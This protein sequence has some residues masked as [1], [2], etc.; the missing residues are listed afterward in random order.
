MNRYRTKIGKQRNRFLLINTKTLK[1][2]VKPSWYKISDSESLVYSPSPAQDIHYSWWVTDFVTSCGLCS[3]TRHYLWVKGRFK[4]SS[5]L[6]G[7]SERKLY[8]KPFLLRSRFLVIHS[9]C[10]ANWPPREE[11]WKQ[12][13]LPQALKAKTAEGSKGQSWR[14]HGGTSFLPEHSPYL[15]LLLL[16]RI[17]RTI[18]HDFCSLIWFAKFFSINS[19][20][21][22]PINFNSNATL[23][24]F[25]SQK[26]STL[27]LLR[28]DFTYYV[29]YFQDLNLK[30][31]L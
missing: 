19:L 21:I 29:F 3:R 31:I 23:L 26:K 28:V 4:T 30:E 5:G 8:Q 22:P 2:P 18:K 27:M 13:S 15:N 14:N 25:M 17:D 7:R 20:E 9:T 11:T 1:Y 10:P 6:I 16:C 24:C 12:S